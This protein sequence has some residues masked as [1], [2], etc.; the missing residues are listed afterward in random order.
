M[1]K[2]KNIADAIRRKLVGDPDLA[3]AVENARFGFNVS[4][5][6]FRIREELGLTQAQLAVRIGSQQSVIARLEDA[7]YEGHSLKLLRKIADATGKRL[8]V[9]FVDK[10]AERAPAAERC[11]QLKPPSAARRRARP[12]RQR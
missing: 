10:I 3:E 2:A 11:D 4:E 7:D 12:P 5:E 6:I 9:R 1:A 8:E